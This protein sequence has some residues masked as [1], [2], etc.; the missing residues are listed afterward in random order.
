MNFN[1][2]SKGKQTAYKDLIRL[3]NFTNNITKYGKTYSEIKE[4]LEYC[5]KQYSSIFNEKTKTLI[6]EYLNQLTTLKYTYHEDNPVFHQIKGELV[7]YLL[8]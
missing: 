8:K 2:N 1:I 5:T 7:S 6:S 3:Q 4:L